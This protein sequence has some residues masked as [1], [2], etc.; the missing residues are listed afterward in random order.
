M[1]KTAANY[2][3]FAHG[4]T[5]FQAR[6]QTRSDLSRQVMWKYRERSLH[7]GGIMELPKHGVLGFFDTLRGPEVGP[8]A[9]KVEQLGYDALWVPEVMG[10]EI[11]SLSTY[12]LS[13]TERV[14][15]GTGVAIAY[16][17]EPIAAMG[18]ARA[19]S[20]FFGNRFIFGLGVSNK[21]YNARRGIGYEKPVAFMRDYIAKM[22]AAPYNAPTPKEEPPIVIAAM[23]PKMLEL[24][25]TETHGT[26]T[27]FTTTEQVAGYR[28]ALGPKPWLAAVQLVMMESDAAKARAG[29][30]RYMQI[31]LAIE[32]YLQRLRKLGFA[33]QDFANGGSDRLIDAIIAWG[34]E[35]QIRER[36]DAQFR[37]GAN[38]VCIV[39][40][41]SDGGLGADERCL[42][43]LAP[44]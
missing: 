27:Y 13:Q 37:V 4:D 32:H 23:M 29:A 5:H 39:P 31:Y 26:L 3:T 9:R 24:A 42:V 10:R 36:I 22:K 25:A 44:R 12:V 41:R 16:S 18:A 28:K 6:E 30:R 14:V 19:M 15:V 1:Q 17:Y 8:F 20:E 7:Y 34:N 40:L 33:E 21:T 11:F 35:G 38:H 2:P 43:A